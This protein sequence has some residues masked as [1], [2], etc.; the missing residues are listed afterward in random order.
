MCARQS[1]HS[2]FTARKLVLACFFSKTGK[3]PLSHRKKFQCSESEQ[4][5]S[6]KASAKLALN[7]FWVWFF[8]QPSFWMIQALKE[9]FVGAFLAIRPSSFRSQHR[10]TYLRSIWIAAPTPSIR[11]PCPERLGELR[12]WPREFRWAERICHLEIIQRLSMESSH[13][14]VACLFWAAL[15]SFFDLLCPQSSLGL[16]PKR[17]VASRLKLG[18]KVQEA[19]KRRVQG[20]H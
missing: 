2:L 18:S 5:S 11:T 10:S 15:E 6:Q 17:L 3:V 1:A 12:F 19:Q 20:H 8:L 4:V 13:Q 14:K 9:S 16:R 7:A